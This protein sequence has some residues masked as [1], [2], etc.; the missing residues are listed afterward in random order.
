[1][2]TITEIYDYY[3]LLFLNIGERSC[4][5]CGSRVRKDS[6][7]SMIDWI[8]RYAEGTRFMVRANYEK[9]K[10]F[11]DFSEIKKELLDLGFIRFSFFTNDDEICTIND[12]IE[13]SN[14]PGIHII[15]DRLVVQ[16]FQ[17]PEDSATKRLKDSIELALKV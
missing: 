13:V 10:G 8:S 16:D 2:G 5:H 4:I 11:H 12:T 3:K 9:K 6:L 1:M 17:D 7:T 15:V 14:I